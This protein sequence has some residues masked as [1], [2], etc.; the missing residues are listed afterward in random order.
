MACTLRYAIGHV[1][2]VECRGKGTGDVELIS[3][4]ELV[5]WYQRTYLYDQSAFEV[6]VT[7]YHNQVFRTAYAMLGNGQDA[8]DVTQDVFVQVY[9]SL[10]SL[11][12]P[13]TLPAWIHRITINACLGALARQRRQLAQQR[14]HAPEPGGSAAGTIAV[15]ADA[16]TE[17]PE[18]HALRCELH[19]RIK[20]TL[21]QLHPMERTVLV[22]RDVEDR[23]YQ[24]IADS[25]GIALSA[26]KMRIHRARRSFQRHFDQSYLDV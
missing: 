22:L 6:L 24:E 9:R 4:E 1:Y 7:Q 26:V 8:E 15:L 3:A 13:V 14:L 16:T 19:Q 2:A 17:T 23:S 5:Q 12:Q 21:A 11:V 18:E 20:T 10:Q 25:L